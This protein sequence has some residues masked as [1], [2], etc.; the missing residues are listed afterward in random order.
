MAR[1]S[2][3]RIDVQLLRPTPEHVLMDLQIPRRLRHADPALPDQ[4]N[5][6][7][8]EFPRKHS[9]SHGPPPASSNTFS[10]CPRNQQ[11]ARS[12]AF[13][14]GGS[15]VYSQQD[16]GVDAAAVGAAGPAGSGPTRRAN[17]NIG[18]GRRFP[19]RNPSDRTLQR[20]NSNDFANERPDGATTP[21]E[22]DATHSRS[23][24]CRGCFV[25]SGGRRRGGAGWRGRRGLWRRRRS[26][27][28]GWEGFRRR[29]GRRFGGSHI[30]GLGGSRFGGFGGSH[31]GGFGGTSI[32][33]FGGSPV[34]GFGGRFGSPLGGLSGGADS[35]M[36]L[37]QLIPIALQA[38]LL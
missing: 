24:C 36:P 32:G 26:H 21:L 34:G 20:A 38:L 9:P 14:K 19:I 35:L 37:W 31:V 28:R 7:N 10:R 5:R 3:H 6:L 1:K 30:G 15:H 29:I 27:R 17:R 18:W 33:G 2:L 4:P 13:A 12:V 25:R 22:Y 8:L 11:Q 16:R 23:F